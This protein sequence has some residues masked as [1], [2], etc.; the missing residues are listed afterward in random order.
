[1]M[2]DKN[3]RLQNIR[4]SL[5]HLLAASVLEMYPGA[6]NAIGPAVENGF[7]QD[8]ETPMPISDEDLPKIEAR[9]REILQQW[10]PFIRREVDEHEAREQFVGNPYKLELIDEFAKGGKRLTFYTCG[11][12]IDLCKGGHVNDAHEINPQVFK[13]VKVS[14]AYWRGD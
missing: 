9:M 5:A 3:E 14:G 6:K 13:L 2:E 10:G 1:M 8:F 11:D 4:H 12:F 7:Y